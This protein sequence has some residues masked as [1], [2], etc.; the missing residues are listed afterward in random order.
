MNYYLM[1]WKKY[2]TFSGRAQR[3]EYWTFTLVN[4]G[5]YFLLLVLYLVANNNAALMNLAVLFN[6]AILLP[7]LAVTARRLHDTGHKGWWILIGLIPLVGFIIL[8]VF[9][10]SDSTP[11][12]N[13]YDQNPKGIAAPTPSAPAPT[14]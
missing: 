14:Q 13:K 4:M 5:I 11:G 2:V 9:T 3:A 12:D 10:L 8:L 6:L 1:P 7:T